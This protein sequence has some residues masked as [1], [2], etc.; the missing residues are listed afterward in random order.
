MVSSGKYYQQ[1]LIIGDFPRGVVGGNCSP[2]L[3][4]NIIGP[5][6]PHKLSSSI[7]FTISG[8]GGWRCVCVAQL[9]VF[10]DDTPFLDLFQYGFY[11]SHG[12]KT[13]LVVI[14]DDLWRHFC[15]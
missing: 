1:I 3:E 9:Q 14:I 8:Q 2:P 4:E 13:M 10:L 7:E 11:P 12:I 5:D 15:G 6:S